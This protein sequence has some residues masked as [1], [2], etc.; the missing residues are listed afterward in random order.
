MKVF[1]DVT[2]SLVQLCLLN[3]DRTLY[4]NDAL[5]DQYIA[6]RMK[7]EMKLLAELAEMSL[8][9]LKTELSTRRA[10]LTVKRNGVK[11][12]GTEVVYQLLN[13]LGADM[14]EWSEIRTEAFCPDGKIT[15]VPEVAG[16][17]AKLAQRYYLAFGTSSPVGLAERVLELT[18]IRQAVPNACVFGPETWHG[19]AIKASPGFFHAVASAFRCIASQVISIGNQEFSDVTPALATGYAGAILITGPEELGQVVRL[20]S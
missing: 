11:A 19:R 13:D 17:M 6:A 10:A 12:T 14:G 8:D 18:G 1:G 7:T 4:G 3:V 15:I 16:W 20:L 2:T 5:A 9:E